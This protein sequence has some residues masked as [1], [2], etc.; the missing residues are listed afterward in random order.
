MVTD[1]VV[2]GDEREE[3]QELALDLLAIGH[4]E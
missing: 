2:L 4:I 1:S 3:L